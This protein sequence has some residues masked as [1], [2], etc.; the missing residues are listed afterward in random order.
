MKRT[1]VDSSLLLSAGYDAKKQVLELEFDSGRIY[2]YEDVSPSEHKG[3]MEADSH[4]RYFLANIK[5]A[6]SYQR[7]N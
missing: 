5:G 6:Y 2:Q 1:A 7:L 3:L 4:G